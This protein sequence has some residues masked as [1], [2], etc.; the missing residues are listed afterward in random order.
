MQKQRIVYVDVIKVLL[1]CLVVAHHAGQAYGPTGGVWPVTDS[2]K[3]N[4]LGHFFFINASYMMGLYFFISGY[5]MLFSLQRKTNTQF[6]KDRLVRLGIP[7]FF[8][9]FL[10]FL[11]FNYLG[12]STGTNVFLFFIDT[13]FNKPPIATG[14]LWFV[15]S[16]L[17]YSFIYLLLFPKRHELATAGTSRPFKISYIV[18]Y[19]LLLTLVTAWVRLQYPIDVWRTWLIPVE[20]AHIPQYLSLFLIGALFNRYRWLDTFKLSTG[21]LFFVV[22]IV[23]YATNENLPVQIKDYWLTEAFIESLLCVGISMA[24][25]TLFRHYGNRSNAVI[26]SLSDNAYGIYLF[27]VLIVIALQQLLLNWNV[28]ANLKFVTVAVGGIVLSLWLSALL[29]KIKPIR[30]VI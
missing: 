1:T 29:R 30:S 9:T 27:H 18:I 5:F 25:L 21:L 23:A 3:T 26:R 16:L 4:W 19:I 12:S 17:L 20:V 22:A 2:S 6:I 7:L 13:Y 15:A 11:P 28:N 8:F 14:H 10:V 24:L